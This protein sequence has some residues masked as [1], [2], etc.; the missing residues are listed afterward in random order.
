M[1]ALRAKWIGL[2]CWAPAGA[3]NRA[4]IASGAAARAARFDKTESKDMEAPSEGRNPDGR[5]NVRCP[6]RTGPDVGCGHGKGPFHYHRLRAA[7]R[8]RRS[9]A[10]LSG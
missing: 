3:A 1:P 8:V 4:A 9:S 2:I 6:W 10:L 7:L 5:S